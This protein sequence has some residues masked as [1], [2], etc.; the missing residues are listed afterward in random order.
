MQFHLNALPLTARFIDNKL[1]QLLR[2]INSTSQAAVRVCGD[3]APW[4]RTNMNVRLSVAYRV[5]HR[6]GNGQNKNE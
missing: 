6:S 3:L 4:F 1:I 5:H 2:D